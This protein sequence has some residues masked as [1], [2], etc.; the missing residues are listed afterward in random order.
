MNWGFYIYCH[1]ERREKS[2]NLTDFS[3]NP[4]GFETME[5]KKL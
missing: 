4:L 2:F 5:L 1:F 3:H